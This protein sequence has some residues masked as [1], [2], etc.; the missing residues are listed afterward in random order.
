MSVA[1]MSRPRLTAAVVRGL[2][3]VVMLADAD[4]AAGV[5]DDFDDG[6]EEDAIIGT[7]ARCAP[8]TARRSSHDP[9]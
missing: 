1:K 5:G 9:R 4:L 3:T 7:D 6:E 2:R 8:R